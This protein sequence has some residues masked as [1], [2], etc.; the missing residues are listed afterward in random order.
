MLLE[1][2]EILQAMSVTK[3]ALIS[4]SSPKEIFNHK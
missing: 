3:A 1:D 4:E 2:E